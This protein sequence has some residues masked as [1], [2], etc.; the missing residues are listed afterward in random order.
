[1]SFEGRVALV[2]GAGSGIGE[3]CAKRLAAGRA[4]VVVA[5]VNLDGARRV[6][7]EI[8]ETGGLASSIAC[9]VADADQVQAMVDHAISTFGG[10]HLAVNNAGISSTPTLLHETPIE[11]F[12]R[13]QAVNVRGTMLCM[14]AQL[15]HMVAN[16]GG[17]IVNIAST[18]GLKAG[19]GMVPYG[20]SKHAVVGLTRNAALDY[21]NLGI[22]VN[23]VAPGP[24]LTP[25]MSA[26]SEE[27]QR[28]W[29][30]PVP[31]RRFGQA[32]EVADAA[33]FLLSDAASFTTGTILETDGGF[34]QGPPRTDT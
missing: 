9:D 6:V 33:A 5:D 32:R 16:G 30:S 24:I 22:R 28:I 8:I 29:A 3:A 13:V 15:R 21:A 1:M 14:R 34:M 18:S 7:A 23:A 10:L 11:V 31:M 12:D 26:A 19:W 4:S 25:A 2:T 27:Q 20:T 17:A